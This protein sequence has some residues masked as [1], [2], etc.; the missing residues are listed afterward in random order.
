[1]VLRFRWWLCG[2]LAK[3]ALEA[4]PNRAEYM[5]R[6]ETG[7]HIGPGKRCPNDPDWGKD[8]GIRVG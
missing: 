3:K 8:E 2:W 1:M 7:F 4:S 6:Y 5:K